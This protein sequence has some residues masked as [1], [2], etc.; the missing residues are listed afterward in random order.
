MW[1]GDEGF[2]LQQQ[3]RYRGR[4]PCRL[5]QSVPQA[6]SSHFPPL[7]FAQL[8]RLARPHLH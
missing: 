7:F 3:V 1:G 5:I 2:R 4:A 8:A 6:E